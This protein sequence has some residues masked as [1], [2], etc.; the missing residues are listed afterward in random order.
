MLKD[1]KHT[2]IHTAWKTDEQSSDSF[3]L[4]SQ[5]FR[6][7]Q[8]TRFFNSISDHELAIPLLTSAQR[9]LQGS[10]KLLLFE[11]KYKLYFWGFRVIDRIKVATSA[12][13]TSIQANYIHVNIVKPLLCYI[14]KEFQIRWR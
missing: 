13:E 7:T 10:I 5:V 11:T 6:K 3:F 4:G 8:N 12:A 14:N 2:Q 1:K 9:L